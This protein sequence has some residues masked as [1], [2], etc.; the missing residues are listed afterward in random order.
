MTPDPF[1]FRKPP[2][3]EFGRRASAWLA[4]ACRRTP[5][6][7]A[8][9]LPFPAALAVG[10]VEVVGAGAALAALPDDAVSV[11][12]LAGAE[13]AALLVF[14]RPFLLALLAGVVGEVPAALPADRDLTELESSLVGFA[15]RELFLDPLERGWPGATA[16]Q[17]AAGGPGAPRLAWTTHGGDLTDL[18]LFATLDATAP[19]G[20][21]PVYLLVPRDGPWAALAAPEAAPRPPTAPPVAQIEA[22]VRQMPVE[23]E[24]L[25]GTADL[26]MR[27]LSALRAGDVLVLGQKVDEPLDGMLAG[28]RKFRVWPGTVGAKAAVQVDA[29]ADH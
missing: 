5:G 7:W 17:L 12:V 22:L 8:R 19:F 26:S 28:A 14:R 10:Y 24:V 16:P 13:P 20:Q 6:P 29:P 4:A 21:Q 18:A 11:P 15:A 9:V 1:D 23:L 2:P 25:L 3:G 27:E